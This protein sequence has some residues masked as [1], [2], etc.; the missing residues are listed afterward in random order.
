MTTRAPLLSARGLKKSYGGVQALRGMDI[1]LAE[2]E[3]HGLCGENGAGKSTLVKILGGFVTPDDGELGIA[4]QIVPLGRPVDPALLSIVHQELS[5]IPHLSVI[6]NVMMGARDVRALYRRGPFRAHVR[7]TLDAVGLQHVPL[8]L[9]AEKLTLAERQLVEIAR[10]IARGARVLL[11]DEPTATLSDGEIEK[12][13]AVLR[14]LKSENATTIVII[15]HRL[16]EIFALTDRVTVL[17]SGRHILTADTAD[18]TS[19]ALVRAMIGHEVK[20]GEI[21]PSHA[22]VGV[23]PRLALKD[24]SLPGRFAA[25][26]LS[27]QPGEIVA[28]VGQLGSGADMLLESLAG[29]K[30][31]TRGTLSLDGTEATPR[32]IP[33]AY[34]AGIAY[35]SEDRAARGV[36]LDAPIGTNLVSQVLGRV[37]RAGRVLPSAVTALATELAQSFAI[38]PARLP[39]EVSTL[40]GG[41]QQKVSLGKAVA[42]G[43]RLLL[44]NEPTRGVDIGARSEIYARLRALAERDAMTLLFYS[45]DLEEVLEASD[46][47]ITFY[48]GAMVRDAARAEVDADSILHDILH[49][50]DEVAA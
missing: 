22:R 29:L 43:P 14:R 44:L 47:V 13:F 45:T 42:L 36:F 28:L 41:N 3:I 2:G 5:I 27:V 48:R 35:V 19:D 11:L 10:G 46:R 34:A 33:E 16:N 40:S 25:P 23:A 32:S 18:L 12:V 30:P 38:D 8:D 15:S 7:Q 24:W 20:T 21:A 26:D 37:S 4:G 49:G 50:P 6:D 31:G 39:H 1:D 17:R 9:L